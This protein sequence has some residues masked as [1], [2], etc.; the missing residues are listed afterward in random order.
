MSQGN[1]ELDRLF[2]TFQQAL[3]GRYSIDR[4]LGRGGMGIVYMAREVHL[5]RP[6]AIKL[7]PPE[8]VVAQPQLR[9]RF[10]REARL[11]AKLSH[12]NIIPIHAVEERDG[13][14]YYV[15]AYVDGET[16]TQR[17]RSRGPLPATEAARMLREVA[18]ALSYAHGQGLVHR[19]VKPDNILLEHS[20]GRVLVAD[21]GIAA[22]AGEASADGGIAGTPE[23]MSPE[24]ALGASVDARSDLYSLGATAFYAFSGR[25]PFEGSTATEVLAKQVTEP[26]PLLAA[27]GV[28]VPRKIASLVD[29]C[30][31]K[32]PAQ[33]PQNAQA[34]AEQLGVALE[35]RRELPAPLRAF[36]KRARLNGS[37]TMLAGMALLPASLTVS[38]FVGAS[39][40]YLPARIAGF[41]TLALGLTALPFAYLVSSAR[42][43]L[44][45]GFRHQ[46]VAPAFDAELEQAREEL[47]VE[48]RP[49]RVSAFLERWLGRLTKSSAVVWAAFLATVWLPLRSVAPWVQDAFGYSW[50][51]TGAVMSLSAIAL[52]GLKQRHSDVD[53]EFWAR[54]W[55]GPIGKTA[56]AIAKRVVGKNATATAMTHRATELSLGMAAEQLYEELTK[57][58]RQHLGDL[59]GVLRRLQEDAQSLRKRYD[60]L[61]QTLSEAGSGASMPAFADVR[62]LRDSIHTKLGDA[63]A[64]METIRLNLLRLHAG[65]VTVESLTTHLGLA[66]DVSAEVERLI[67]GQDEV[68]QALKFPREATATPV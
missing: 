38:F 22:A 32:D 61:Q 48:R 45:L 28:P 24:Q 5:D 49:T 34:L 2:F 63:V 10:L 47:A 54:L 62:A 44:K 53:T 39:V 36:A 52:V 12:P 17:V 16:L 33:R 57:E 14:V 3:A 19:D 31:A 59:P 40:G 43:I 67:R 35:K 58:Q 29:H 18:W 23:F 30:L 37:G 46:D 7:V 8:R 65:S 20:G 56:F 15:M 13:F 41:T 26:A 21:F 50:A 6:V 68:E 42:R 64:A 27:M 1:A 4:E 60:D 55:K 66:A 25:F 9:D 11:A 51:I